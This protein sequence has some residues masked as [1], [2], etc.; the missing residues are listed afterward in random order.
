MRRASVPRREQKHP[1]LE[2]AV[3]DYYTS[4]SQNEVEEQISWGEF[5]LREFPNDGRLNPR[6]AN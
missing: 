1:A 6:S 3:S 4:L 5:A 2:R